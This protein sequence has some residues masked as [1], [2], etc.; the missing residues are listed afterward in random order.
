MYPHDLLPFDCMRVA[1]ERAKTVN[2]ADDGPWTVGVRDA[3]GALLASAM[4]DSYAQVKAFTGAMED[5][6]FMH[7]VLPA[8]ENVGC[9]DFTFRRRLEV[10]QLLPA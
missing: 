6:G 10:E 4:L 9:C 2:G 5:L 3:G 8:Q 1:V 7:S